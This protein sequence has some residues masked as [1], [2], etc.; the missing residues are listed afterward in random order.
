M[1]WNVEKSIDGDNEMEKPAA[2]PR[3]KSGG[4]SPG[5]RNIV[6]L[7]ILALGW[8]CFSGVYGQLANAQVTV[9]PRS[10]ELHVASTDLV[11]PVGPVVLEV[12][13][14]LQP[15]SSVPGV[16][17]RRWRLN[18]ESQLLK[19]GDAVVVQ[20][21][22]GDILFTP[23]TSKGEYRGPLG[24]RLVYGSDGRAVRSKGDGRREIFDAA[25]R[26]VERDARNGNT[27]RLRYGAAGQLAAVEG[28]YGS[29]LRFVVDGNGLVSRVESSTG[30]VLRYA[31][32]QG[33]LAQVETADGRLT[34]YA[35][36]Q[37]G[38][39]VRVADAQ[40]G[41][42][43]IA[44]DE[45]GRVVKR[46][47]ADG[48]QEVL[49]YEDAANRVRHTDPAGG[50]TSWSWSADRRREEVMDPLGGISTL[51]YDANSRLLKVTGPT[52][53]SV[54][55][56]Y[57]ALGRLVS[58][59]DA[60]GQ[61]TRHEYL[62]EMSLV[63][64]ITHPNGM[65]QAFDYDR[66]R[67]LVAIKNEHDIAVTFTYMSNG[68]IESVKQLDGSEWRFAYDADGRL[69]TIK[70][71]LG[72][73][74]Q[75]EYN[76]RGNLIREINPLGGVTTRTY[77]I[78]GRL[79]SLVDAA[80]ATSRYEYAPSGL[81]TRLIDPAGGV[82]QY[83]YDALGRLGTETDPAGRITQYA[84]YP[85]GHLRSVTDA[86]G[87]SFR[88]EHDQGGNL[89]RVV[90]PLGGVT[91]ADYDALGR[92]RSITDAAGHTTRYESSPAGSL[93]RLVDPTGR[94]T[95]FEYD[96]QGHLVKVANEANRVIRY[97]YTPGGLLA[98][99][100]PPVG[101]AMAYQYDRAGNRISAAAGND[102]VVRYQYDSL[103]RRIREQ[104][105]MGLEIAYRYDA[106]GNLLGWKDSLGAGATLQYD[107]QGQATAVTDA[108]GAMT[109]YRYDLTGNLLSVTDALGHSQRRVYTAAGELA[110][111]IE[112][113]GDTAKYEYD[114]TGRLG[115]VRHP[116]GGESQFAYDPLGN[117][118]KVTNPLGKERHRT[119]DAAGR[120]LSMTDTKGQVTTF[121][122]D[123][124]GRLIQKRLADSKVVNYRYDAQG[125]LAQ[126][127]DGA[128]PLRYSYDADRRLVQVA[129]PAI[130]RTLSYEYDAAGLLSKFVDSEGRTMRYEYDSAKR[131][132]AIKLP[133]DQSIA[134]AYDA[135][136]RLTSLTYPNGVKGSWAYDVA[137]RPT[138]ITYRDASGKSLTGWQYTYDAAGNRIG[139]I[140]GQ[141]RTTRYQYDP[142]G[143]LVEE[144]TGAGKTVRY[145]YLPGGNR[146]NRDSDGKT[147]QYRY[148][149]VDRLLAVGEE[150]LT[151]DAN[152]NLVERRGPS[153]TTR[154]AYDPED[155]LVKVVKTD[156]SEISFGY[157]PTGERVWR[158]D[159]A[160]LTY[161]VTDG[162]NLLA[163]LSADLKPSATYLHGPGIDRP[164][165]MAREGQSYFY[166][167][168]LL[169]S[170]ASMTD[171]GGRVA[172][173]YDYDAFGN[174]RAKNGTL[175]NSF[176]F[177]GREY[178]SV[179]GLYFYRARYYD[180]ML[181]RFLSPDPWPG[182]LSK[183]RSL[184]PYVYADNNPVNYSDPSG[185]A[186]APLSPPAQVP[187]RPG[188]FRFYTGVD[189]KR[190]NPQ[191][192]MYEP[193][194]STA[195][196]HGQAQALTD[197]RAAMNEINPATIKIPMHPSTGRPWGLEGVLTAN[198]KGTGPGVTA[199]GSSSLVFITTKPEVAR[200][201]AGAM[202]KVF[203]LDVP[204]SELAPGGLVTPHPWARA[205]GAHVV[206]I[207][208]PDHWIA[209]EELI[210]P[211][212]PSPPSGGE[213]PGPLGRLGNFLGNIWQGIRNRLPG[214]GSGSQEEF[215]GPAPP[216][217]R[218]GDPKYGALTPGGFIVAGVL[219]GLASAAVCDASG[220]NRQQC[221]DAAQ[222]GGESA[223]VGALV[224]EGARRAGVVV[225]G[226]VGGTAVVVAAAG[227]GAYQ[228][229]KQ[230]GTAFQEGRALQQAGA[231]LQQAAQLGG[232]D[233]SVDG[234]SAALRAQLSALQQLARQIEGTQGKVTEAA[235]EGDALVQ[236]Y[237]GLQGQSH[238]GGTTAAGPLPNV[239][240]SCRDASAQ[241]PDLLKGARDM[242]E[243]FKHATTLL[244][245]PK[246]NRARGIEN[247]LKVKD[248]LSAASTVSTTM[249]N[250]SKQLGDALKA[251]AAFKKTG[252]T[253]PTEATSNGKRLEQLAVTLQNLAVQI[254]N[255][256][257]QFDA[258]KQEILTSMMRVRSGVSQQFQEKINTFSDEL[259]A[260]KIPDAK[261]TVALARA[262]GDTF[263]KL[264]PETSKIAEAAVEALKKE[265]AACNEVRGG[266]ARWRAEAD[267]AWKAVDASRRAFEPLYTAA[268]KDLS[269]EV[270]QF[271]RVAEHGK[272]K[273]QE[274]TRN[275]NKKA[276]DEL[277]ALTR[278]ASETQNKVGQARGHLDEAKGSLSHIGQNASQ[279]TQSLTVEQ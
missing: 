97:E 254:D 224:L 79:R 126:V 63:A 147:V 116:G 266:P 89:R 143:Q 165:M 65:R 133:T 10:G 4:V 96:A 253:L 180:P 182:R 264:G 156:G 78:Q 42:T 164:L 106:M 51:E 276:V 233:Q 227:Y 16:L 239:A 66:Q 204:A 171:V 208:V 242:E 241:V 36:D 252:E 240:T 124:A 93:T 95:H 120:L 214:G 52:K 32:G 13:R 84:Y 184:N 33:G 60:A 144:H 85:D 195:F 114:L 162:I 234:A 194:S 77:D 58:T 108:S 172:M 113:T 226:G 279:S 231:E 86:A 136:D 138:S 118:I 213:P 29:F 170:V 187:D 38:L 148:D 18:W 245:F 125:N 115:K 174:L 110:E 119:Y 212:S 107:A 69:A 104:F 88:F 54:S 121:T 92:L 183:P 221:I 163:E 247:A 140:D 256:Q 278:E 98:K 142:A 64:A 12:R 251:I 178:E 210:R 243:K 100:V 270:E 11:V 190:F 45:K 220:G 152:G 2:M 267:G 250:S 225:A 232:S 27:M 37:A 49:A 207:G 246:D 257:K 161:F 154:Y 158:R 255:D 249:A 191:T 230:L 53:L 80:G 17:G 134:F 68:L 200:S 203:T 40:A 76:K 216:P 22:V 173:A 202:G 71:A 72:H 153:G 177:T 130:K 193:V 70:D 262:R 56:S 237:A 199:P 139:T 73:A 228:T 185:G 159:S 215:A 271:R 103:G 6:R 83:T 21:E 39:L 44:Y 201:Y 15:G 75:L 211:P 87:Q 137:N 259:V 188:F 229:G 35:Y 261:A 46:R 61:T 1:R 146:G 50:V 131:L 91:T 57:D 223:L 74:T 19:R 24:E 5:M 23:A 28:P 67:N 48:S 82:T 14:W 141:N 9:D 59:Q 196:K 149:Q 166:H 41:T 129:Y 198:V 111:L 123:A 150:T 47:W 31:Y 145:S 128:F 151:Y 135:K 222:Q 169:G 206:P 160:G 8:A 181:G 248:S 157:A 218:P 186:A 235:K 168:D 109:R 263:G 268:L 209:G 81:L 192:R 62:G 34:R 90:N 217:A 127:D 260:T 117:P 189:A 94:A 272:Q 274:A 30:E 99:I 179:I 175:K 20:E 244:N 155:R 273:Q 102:V 258:K 176:A 112:P 205:Q 3:A 7:L 101:P 122:Y 265:L 238:Q 25:G 236:K 105:A 55:F 167:A 26:L 269:E 275:Q 197:L 43:E 219:G 277:G 132:S